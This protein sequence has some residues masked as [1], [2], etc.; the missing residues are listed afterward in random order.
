M[1][2]TSTLV[3]MSPSST[4]FGKRCQIAAR[5]LYPESAALQLDIAH[6]L[7]RRTRK[8]VSQQTVQ[9]MFTRAKQSGLT[10][11]LAA[12]TGVRFE[13]LARGTGPMRDD[14]GIA[15]A[16]P[17]PV[18]DIVGQNPVIASIV[19]ELAKLTDAQQRAIADGVMSITSLVKKPT[20]RSGMDRQLFEQIVLLVDETLS[21]RGFRRGKNMTEDQFSSICA[22]AYAYAVESDTPESAVQR[23]LGSRAGITDAQFEG[24]QN[25]D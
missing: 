14:D 7:S 3:D 20:P 16:E 6:A 11:D 17:I 18:Y 12:I 23:V 2:P 8:T 19:T 21:K 5:A 24:H 15:I 9:Y 10:G 22:D 1:T 13:W 4:E 25:D